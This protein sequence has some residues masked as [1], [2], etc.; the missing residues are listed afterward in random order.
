MNKN[1]VLFVRITKYQYERIKNQVDAKGYRSVS[2]Y[3][4]DL[5]LQPNYLET[6]I[7]EID[8]SIKEILD[9]I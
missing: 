6:K 3:I 4:R 8:K 1:H 9:A 2:A 7:I 5:A